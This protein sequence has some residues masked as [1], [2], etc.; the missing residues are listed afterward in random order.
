MPAWRAR[1]GRGG[2]AA[3]LVGHRARLRDTTRRSYQA[4]VRLYL[5]QYLGSVLLA[6][7]H[8]G[9]L[10]R[11]FARLLRE[12]GLTAAT[13]RRIHATAR[14]VSAERRWGRRSR[15]SISSSEDA[16]QRGAATSNP[17]S[18]SD[19]NVMF[20]LRPGTFPRHG[21]AAARQPGPFSHQPGRNLAVT[22][23]GR[24]IGSHP[25]RY[26]WRGDLYPR[27]ERGRG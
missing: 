14:S 4:H 13:A 24:P 20:Q 15:T 16:A 5:A 17:S 3:D 9:H 18:P 25:F 6:E 22:S 1:A 11:V 12:D 23:D 27:R 8:I 2:L 19:P 10:E 26:R 7:L 21:R